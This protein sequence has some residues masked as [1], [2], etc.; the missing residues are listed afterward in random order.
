MASRARASQ[1]DT[2]WGCEHR[3]YNEREKRGLTHTECRRAS[4]PGKGSD[5][6]AAHGGFSKTPLFLHTGSM[7][8]S[9]VLMQRHFKLHFKK[10]R[11]IISR[12]SNHIPSWESDFHHTNGPTTD[13]LFSSV[14]AALLQPNQATCQMDGKTHPRRPTSKNSQ[15]KMVKA[16]VSNPLT[17]LCTWQG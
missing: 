7:R 12:A 6:R 3:W 16:L 4:L 2:T 1:Q 8:A 5:Q 14:Y 10:T 15:G 13:P 17:T 9:I 11:K